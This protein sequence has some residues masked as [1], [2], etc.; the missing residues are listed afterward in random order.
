MR[1]VVPNPDVE[2]IEKLRPK[3]EAAKSYRDYMKKENKH[4]IDTF[5]DKNYTLPEGIAYNSHE[6]SDV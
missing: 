6:D 4:L 3:L 2:E 5:K 1:L